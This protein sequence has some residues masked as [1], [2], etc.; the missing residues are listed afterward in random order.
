MP[1]VT[2]ALHPR[3]D[4]GTVEIVF[5]E[6][7]GDKVL[8]A[9]K[10][11]LRFMW[12]PQNKLWYGHADEDTVRKILDPLLDEQPGEVSMSAPDVNRE[13]PA[14]AEESLRK[15][16]RFTFF[17]HEEDAVKS[18]TVELGSLNDEEFEKAKRA[19]LEPYGFPE[20]QPA[21]ESLFIYP[22]ESSP[23]A[24]QTTD[25]QNEPSRLS[26]EAVNNVASVFPADESRL[27]LSVWDRQK[28]RDVDNAHRYAYART[29][30]LTPISID[31]ENRTAIFEGASGIHHTSLKRCDCHDFQ[32]RAAACKHM[33]RLAM[34]LGEM[35]GTF[36]SD[37]ASIVRA[38]SPKPSPSDYFPKAADFIELHP[39]G[40]EI[41]F[42]LLKNDLNGIV[43][44]PLDDLAPVKDYIDSDYIF[45]DNEYYLKRSVFDI[46]D[47]LKHKNPGAVTE[48]KSESS[49]R[50]W[51]KQHF[52][53]VAEMLYPDFRILI[54]E[55]TGD[56][57]L[58]DMR[59][60]RVLLGEDFAYCRSD[61]KYYLSKR[62]SENKYMSYQQPIHIHKALMKWDA[63]YAATN[64]P[65]TETVEQNSSRSSLSSEGSKRPQNESPDYKFAYGCSIA[66]LVLCLIF[67]VFAVST[68]FK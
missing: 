39:A 47:A 38:G 17:W 57:R 13:N 3:P 6:K 22:L 66:I 18:E 10:Y 41:V 29:A 33:F 31:R 51:Y 44:L 63:S 4:A 58:V 5:S 21:P 50:Y 56:K 7:P 12:S 2:Y 46:I 42:Q 43:G 64:R 11:D 15:E 45:V 8:H 24:P 34:E 54:D 59:K 55:A 16:R 40:R 36:I 37:E 32:K 49:M 53:E 19:L 52:T 25:Q 1:S 61:L 67:I 60:K 65:R 30:K 48:F 20:D 14:D 68:L 23:A 9:L 26:A 62:A 27:F 35:R 28:T